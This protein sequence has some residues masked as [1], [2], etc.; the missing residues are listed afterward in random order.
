MFVLTKCINKKN[1]FTIK[2]HKCILYS[3]ANV[4]E[5]SLQFIK[6]DII[7]LIK[8]LCKIQIAIKLVYT[9]EY[10]F[11]GLDLELVIAKKLEYR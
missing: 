6:H 3:R 4:N 5:K 2:Y 8:K 10:T 9:R 7:S 1:K 11:D